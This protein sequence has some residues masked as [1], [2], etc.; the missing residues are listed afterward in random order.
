M[1]RNFRYSI[2]VLTI[3]F[4]VTVVPAKAGHLSVEFVK[5]FRDALYGGN[6]TV[7]TLIVEENRDKI[8]A[9]VKALVDEAL[10]PG[11][12]AEDR[13]DK[14]YVAESLATAYKNA[15]GDIGPLKEAKKRIFESRLSPPVRT[16]AVKGVHTVEAVSTE[17][18]KN[19][20]RPQNIIIKKGETVRWVNNDNAAH[21]LASMPVI[22]A[23]GIFSP[24]VEPGQSWDYRFNA[25]GEYYYICFIHKVMY[26][27]ITVEE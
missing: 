14:L 5:K 26:G 13:E 18:V 12:R 25:P 8:P 16:V 22:G 20:F 6:E 24:R 11:A 19:V 17:T 4:V 27:K 21:L 15:T 9:E 3:M 1:S 10:L 7:M 23:Q 2:L